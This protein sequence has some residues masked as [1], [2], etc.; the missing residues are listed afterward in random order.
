MTLGPRGERLIKAFESC[1]R[2]AAGG[3]FCAYLDSVGVPT[4][5]WGHTN[6]LGRQF[7][8]SAVWTQAECDAEFQ[9]D[10]KVFEGHVR[11][12]V[13]VP[14]NQFQFDALVSFAYNCGDGNLAK[15]TLL[16]KVNAGD[17]GGAAQEFG[18]WVN[19]GGKK[20]NGLVRRRKYEARLFQGMDDLT[21]P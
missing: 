21:Y 19:A 13:K 3:K 11:R 2:A 17:F 15:S 10:M 18:K 14:I 7:N 5:G 16:K 12:L 6:H 8:M 1:M 9:S 20:L 4:I